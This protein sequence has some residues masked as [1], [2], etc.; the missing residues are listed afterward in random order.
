MYS[1]DSVCRPYEF[2]RQSRS[3]LGYFIAATMH[4]FGVEEDGGGCGIDEFTEGLVSVFD[5]L[6]T[7]DEVAV[8]E[9]WVFGQEKG[10]YF[11]FQLVYG[12]VAGVL[13]GEG[14]SEVGFD[15]QRLLHKFIFAYQLAAIIDDQNN[16]M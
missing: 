14:L 15:C 9:L 6:P 10:D 16:T 12:L 8:D 13:H 7:V 11:G 2:K 1:I 5:E 3:T 4:P